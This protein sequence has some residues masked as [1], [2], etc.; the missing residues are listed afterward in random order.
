MQW[1]YQ[2]KRFPLQHMVNPFIWA[3]S[4][5][6]RSHLN[7]MYNPACS[8]QVVG[9]D[10]APTSSRKGGGVVVIVIGVVF[11]L[12]L[13]FRLVDGWRRPWTSGHI[14]L[15]QMRKGEL[16][17]REMVGKG[18]KIGISLVSKQC[19]KDITLGQAVCRVESNVIYQII[20]LINASD[21]LSN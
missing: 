17:F 2:K 21:F 9:N 19:W 3:P 20:G 10:V 14:E 13:N 6:D 15:C 1:W 12:D 18:H 16:P 8:I 5:F 4:A 7:C 11:H